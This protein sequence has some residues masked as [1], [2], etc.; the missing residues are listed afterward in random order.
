M[1]TVRIEADVLEQLDAT[2]QE[3]NRSRSDLMALAVREFVE[4]EY[5]SL[6]AIREGVRELAAGKG[7]PHERVSAWID[8]LLAGKGRPK[9][10][11]LITV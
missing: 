9:A 11:P 5:A 3:M 8:D 4:R 2:A 7:V 10:F 1:P 6:S